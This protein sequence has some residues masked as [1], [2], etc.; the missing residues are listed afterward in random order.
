MR[1]QMSVMHAEVPKQRPQA[2]EELFLRFLVAGRIADRDVAVM[3]QGDAVFREREILGRQ[4]EVDRVTGDV[5][6]C[7]GGREA[8]LTRLLAAEH[9]CLRLAD[10][11]DIA[12]RITELLVTQVEVVDAQRLLKDGGVL[13]LGQCQHRLAVVEHVIAADLVGAVGQAV[14]VLFVRRG[15]QKLGAVGRAAGEHHDVSGERLRLAVDGH[16]HLGDPPAGA[17]GVQLQRLTVGQQRDVRVC[18]RRPHADHLRVALGV[19]QT[20]ETVTVVAA[21]AR[22]ERH[23]PFVQ[24]DSTRRVKRVQASRRKIV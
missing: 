5:T 1:Q 23:V 7:P 8:G 10:H 18:E 9:R 12:Q 19:D 2:L 11:L 3:R 14:G 16:L 6:Q 17:V 22:A 15:E 21:H 20:R 4:P 24:A 13:L